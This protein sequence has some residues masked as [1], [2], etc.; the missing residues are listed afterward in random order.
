MV[1]PDT[2]IWEVE[3]EQYS[4]A[5]KKWNALIILTLLGLIKE[6]NRIGGIMASVLVSCAVDRGF[7]PRSGQTKE[8]KIV[9]LH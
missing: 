8:K 4:S 3:Q 6:K 1:S 7:E 2:S 9:F 5:H